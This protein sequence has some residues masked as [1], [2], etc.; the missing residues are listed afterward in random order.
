MLLREKY[1]ESLGKIFEHNKKTE[2]PKKV[3]LH[4]K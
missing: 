1:E 2:S 4:N 3:K